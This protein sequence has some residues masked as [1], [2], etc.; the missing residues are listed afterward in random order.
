MGESYVVAVKPSARRSSAAAGEWVNQHGPR[1]AFASKA[2][3]RE[4]ARQNSAVD[5][6]IWIQDAAPTDSSGI[7][8]YLVGGRRSG[9]TRA[10]TA[11]RQSAVEE[12]DAGGDTGP[13]TETADDPHEEPAEE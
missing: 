6:R 8:G 5:G 7:D 4:W 1:R 9:G 13:S 12:Y 11:N 10:E 2:L 3:A